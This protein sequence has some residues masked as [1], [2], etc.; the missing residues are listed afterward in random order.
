MAMAEEAKDEAIRHFDCVLGLDQETCDEELLA[1][2]NFWKGRCLRMRGE[3]DQ[4]LA[5]AVKGRDLAL[6]LGHEPMAAVMRV[7][8]SWL[9]F[10]KGD[11]KKA[12]DVS[13]RL[14]RC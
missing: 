5:F 12:V 9:F 1:I 7:L 10:Q 14:R 11:A 6:H 4:A 13:K 2:A 8:E 3:Y